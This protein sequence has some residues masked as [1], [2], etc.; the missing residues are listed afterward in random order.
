MSIAQLYYKKGNFIN[1]IQLDVVINEGATATARVTENPV[2]YGA[3]VNDHVI[4]EPMA[5]SVTGVVSNISS[6]A[7]GAISTGRL[8]SA[9]SARAKDAW[10]SLLLLHAEKTPFTLVQGLKEYENVVILSISHQQDKDTANGLFFSATLK[11]IIF[12]G[13]QTITTDQFNDQDTSDR[14]IPAIDG[15]LKQLQ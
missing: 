8:F 6:S 2:E 7:I 3:N 5:F 1:N 14:A 12:V 10:E 4:I 11:E 15:G 13:T 9:R